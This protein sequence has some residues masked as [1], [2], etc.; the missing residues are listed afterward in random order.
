[1]ETGKNMSGGVKI[2]GTVNGDTGNGTYGTRGEV[3]V[4]M[5]TNSNMGT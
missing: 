2:V 1:M 4:K 5:G 3:Q